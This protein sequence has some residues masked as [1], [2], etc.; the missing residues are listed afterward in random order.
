MGDPKQVIVVDAAGKNS[1]E[2]EAWPEYDDQ[3]NTS[4]KAGNPAQS[5]YSIFENKTG[6]FQAGIWSSSPGSVYVTYEMNECF[7]L[8]EGRVRLISDDGTVTEV[9]PGQVMVT[10]AGW[11]GTWEI[12]EATRKVYTLA[13][14]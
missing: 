11:T 12:L 8:L 4:V 10:P 6:D 7:Y 14:K 5:G 3:P 9:G 1:P 2:L 13:A